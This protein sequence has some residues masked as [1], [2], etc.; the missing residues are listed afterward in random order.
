MDTVISRHQ[1]AY[2][3]GISTTDALFQFVE[4]ITQELDKLAN[5]IIQTACLDL[6]KV[7][8]RLQPS[9]VT[10]KMQLNSVYPNLIAL[11]TNVRQA[12]FY[13]KAFN[14]DSV[15]ICLIMTKI[16]HPTI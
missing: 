6:S 5:K 7:I 12:F 14:Y 16:L 13:T 1:Y 8:D 11:V 15:V 4:D 10:D 3:P 9:I 2:R